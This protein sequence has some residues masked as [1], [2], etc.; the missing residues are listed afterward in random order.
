MKFQSKTNDKILPAAF[1]IARISI[2][3]KDKHSHTQANT[4]SDVSTTL[5][6]FPLRESICSAVHLC[7]GQNVSFMVF[8]FHIRVKS[9]PCE[10]SHS[11]RH[12][13]EMEFWL[14]FAVVHFPCS[15]RDTI[16]SSLKTYKCME[17]SPAVGRVLYPSW[18]CDCSINQTHGFHFSSISSKYLCTYKLRIKLNK[19]SIFKRSMIS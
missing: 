2:A 6:A 13:F 14:G 18:C 17:G 1:G 12:I 8:H 3:C 9:I 10:G 4:Q 5:Q 7:C 19:I 16:E 15:I 11:L